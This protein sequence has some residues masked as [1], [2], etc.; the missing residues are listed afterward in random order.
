MG[1]FFVRPF[2]FQVIIFGDVPFVL[3]GRI[4]CVEGNLMEG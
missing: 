1:S 4:R 3:F 2:L